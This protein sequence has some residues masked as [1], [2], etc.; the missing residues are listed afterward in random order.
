MRSLPGF[1][2]ASTAAF[3]GAL[4]A[5]AVD[6]GWASNHR[7]V[8]AGEQLCDRVIEPATTSTGHRHD[9]EDP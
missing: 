1:C 3:A 8:S 7:E 2:A 6:M 9:R 4:P 5:H